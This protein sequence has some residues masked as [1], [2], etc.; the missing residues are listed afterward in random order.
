MSRKDAHNFK[1]ALRS[2]KKTMMPKPYKPSFRQSFLCFFLFLNL[3]TAFSQK[4]ISFYAGAGANQTYC[5][6]LGITELKNSGSGLPSLA[7]DAGMKI[8]C[9]RHFS[10][11]LKYM[12]LS[13]HIRTRFKDLDVTY[14]NRYSQTGGRIGSLS[15]TDDIYLYGNLCGLSFNYE[16]PIQGDHLIFTLGANKLFYNSNRNHI[17]RYYESL[18]PALSGIDVR[19]SANIRGPNPLAL[20]TAI[21]Y[22]KMLYRNRL[23]LYAR[24]EFTYNFIDYSYEYLYSDGNPR[25]YSNTYS[26]MGLPE[27]FTYTSVTGSTGY[28]RYYRIMFH[29]LNFTAGIFYK[30]NFKNTEKSRAR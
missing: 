1:S 20:S 29:T 17:D 13:N 8:K 10:F 2:C 30:L 11:A 14:F 12:Y 21:G 9:S 6:R 28:L 25:T 5:K 18:P 15:F 4:G 3:L 23:G 26:T 24:L 16:V 7:L 27:S 22:E 19:Q